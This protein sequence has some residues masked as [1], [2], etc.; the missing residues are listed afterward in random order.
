MI[1]ISVISQGDEAPAAK[2]LSIHS[3]AIP[4]TAAELPLPRSTILKRIAGLKPKF[5]AETL[6]ASAALQKRAFSPLLAAAV[7]CLRTGDADE[8]FS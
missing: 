4:S 5:D 6:S 2:V 1:P 3:A 7:N 8:Y